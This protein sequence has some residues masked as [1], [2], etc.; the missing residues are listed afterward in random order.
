MQI[1]KYGQEYPVVGKSPRHLKNMQTSLCE[2]PLSHRAVTGLL[3]LLLLCVLREMHL[4]HLQSWH[5]CDTHLNVPLQLH[6]LWTH[7]YH[8]IFLCCFFTKSTSP[9][10]LLCAECVWVVRSQLRWMVWQTTIVFADPWCWGMG[11]GAGENVCNE[12]RLAGPQVLTD[13]PGP[14]LRAENSMCVMY[15]Q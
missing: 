5:L 7:P 2:A 14:S 12:R 9:Q 15:S 1:F 11:C 6:T 13:T 8:F 4:G 10:S 3:I